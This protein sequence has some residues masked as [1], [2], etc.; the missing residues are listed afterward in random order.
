[1]VG[2]RPQVMQPSGGLEPAA[3]AGNRSAPG[4]VTGLSGGSPRLGWTASTAASLIAGPTPRP[5]RAR[6][7]A[8]ADRRRRP[9]Q[10]VQARMS[11]ARFQKQQREKARRERAA[12]KWARREERREAEQAAPGPAAASVDQDA[13]LA[14]IAELH[15]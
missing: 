14:E 4:T 10:E 11:Q 1:M 3:R 2:A 6:W 15:A 9:R 12:A 5:R 7:P 13:V 8:I